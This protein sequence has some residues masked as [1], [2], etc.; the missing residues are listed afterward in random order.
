MQ[1]VGLPSLFPRAV[2]NGATR[3]PT[4]RDVFV[5]YVPT[6]EF[7]T[8][9]YYYYLLYI[10]IYIYIYGYWISICKS[11]TTGSATLICGNTR[12]IEK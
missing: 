6:F 5:V 9:S 7:F 11:S 8:A 2:E 4:Q 3:L 10:Y 12:N 1:N